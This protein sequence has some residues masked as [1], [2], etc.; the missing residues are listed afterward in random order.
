[1]A[2]GLPWVAC[3]EDSIL[4]PKVYVEEKLPDISENRHTTHY[5]KSSI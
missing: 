4:L 2:L 1:M 3:P 5:E